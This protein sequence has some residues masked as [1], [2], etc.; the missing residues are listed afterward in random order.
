M[1]AEKLVSSFA[2]PLFF[3]GIPKGV[4]LVGH[5]KGIH[6][7]SDEEKQNIKKYALFLEESI[8]S[9]IHL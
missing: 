1:L 7:F 2:V 3:N 8:K 6:I 5:R 9:H 4:L